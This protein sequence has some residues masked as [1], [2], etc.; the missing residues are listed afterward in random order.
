MASTPPDDEVQK[1]TAVSYIKAWGESPLPPTLLATLLTALHLSPSPNSLS[2]PTRFLPRTIPWLFPPALLF[3]TYLNLSGYTTSA[4]GTSAA[5]SAL[6]LVMAARG[7]RRRRGR[8]VGMGKRTDTLRQ[9]FGVRGAVRGV[10]GGVAW[11]NVGG[12]GLVY[13]MGGRDEEG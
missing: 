1:T 12:G 8:M 4:A 6:W 3:S 5:W 9:M 13:G 11:A 7:R 2:S 10:A